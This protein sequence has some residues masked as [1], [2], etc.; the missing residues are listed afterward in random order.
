[1]T[2]TTVTTGGGAM[3]KI[4]RSVLMS[5]AWAIFRQ[6]Y[7]YPQIKFADIGRHCF[8]W[9]LKQAWVEARE[10]ARVA[11]LTDRQGRAYRDTQSSHRPR[12]LHRL[13]SAMEGHDQRA[14]R[15]N[16]PIAV[17]LKGELAPARP[18]KTETFALPHHPTLS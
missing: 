2:K 7:R 4:N 18:L 1:M 6:T 11:A 17:S 9:S 10:A 13:R 15:R 3:S 16:P 12:W 14:P 8:A 5:R